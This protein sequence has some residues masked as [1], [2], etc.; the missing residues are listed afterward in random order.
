M[1]EDG[2]GAAAAATPGV[3][4]GLSASQRRAELRRRKLLMNSEERINRIMGFHRPAAK[5]ESGAAALR[6]G[7]AVGPGGAEGSAEP[8][9]LPAGKRGFGPKSAGMRP[10]GLWVFPSELSVPCGEVSVA[11]GGVKRARVFRLSLQGLVAVCAW[12][13]CLTF[14]YQSVTRC[15]WWACRCLA[16]AQTGR[17]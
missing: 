10:C 3:P 16:D 2:G 15:L 7:G 12:S 1:E 8:P 5:G 4:S 13:S 9:L 6:C 11:G 14:G 17:L